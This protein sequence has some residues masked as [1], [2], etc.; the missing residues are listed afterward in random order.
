M[1]VLDVDAERSSKVLGREKQFVTMGQRA[2][3]DDGAS[4]NTAQDEYSK[5]DVECPNCKDMIP[6]D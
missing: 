6:G 3:A 4:L 5:D 1:Q 2:G